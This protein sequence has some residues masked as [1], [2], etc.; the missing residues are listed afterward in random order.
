[1]DSL[2]LEIIVGE[3]DEFD[4]NT[5]RLS[6]D[7]FLW[8]LR[9]Y[10]FVRGLLTAALLSTLAYFALD[11]SFLPGPLPLRILG[12]VVLVFFIEFAWFYVPTIQNHRHLL[13]EQGDKYRSEFADALS[14]MG[15]W[16]LLATDWILGKKGELD[17]H[18]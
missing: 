1:M 7:G 14:E 11:E 13:F 12:L 4:M 3:H 2:S 16:K 15:V 8:A 5:R 18:Q 9:T 10:H 6:T 17:R